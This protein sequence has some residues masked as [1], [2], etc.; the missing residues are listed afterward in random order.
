MQFPYL[1]FIG[2]GNLAYSLIS[3]LIA[4]N[5]PPEKI[6]V[7]RRTQEKLDFFKQQLNVNVTTDNDQ[8]CESADVVIFCLKPQTLKEAIVNL[9]LALKKRNPLIIS[10]AAGIE[11]KSLRSWLDGVFSIVRAMPNTPSFLQAGAT[12]LW[13]NPDVSPTQKS[14]AES[15]FRAVG[16]CVW[17]DK[18]SD[19]NIV[20]ALSGSGPAYFFSLMESLEKA[21]THAGL[22]EKKARLLTLQTAIGASRMAL[23]SSLAPNILRQNVT[24]PSG[25]TEAALNV[26][27]S[28]HFDEL[29]KEAVQ[30]AINRAKELSYTFSENSDELSPD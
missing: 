14:I 2:A 24:S 25:T 29:I 4:D 23:E 20:T 10:V 5:Y 18:E 1:A 6:T 16:L 11:E 12:G 26:F 8:A 19:I 17:L 30:A 22:D 27:A 28:Q 15:L 9:R 21:A 3:G 13:A 7:T